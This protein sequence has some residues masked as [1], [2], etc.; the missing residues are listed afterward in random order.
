[1][2]ETIKVPVIVRW[3][4]AAE[5]GRSSGPP[6]GTSPYTPTGRFSEQSL[7]EMFSVVLSNSSALGSSDHILTSGEIVPLFPE[8]I[9]DF[10][11]RLARGDKF[12]LHEGRRAVAECV[13][14][15]AGR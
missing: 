8:K 1:M 7:D 3:Y 12:I 5:G 10:A 15:G 2:T 11:E 4:T 13:V 14:Q 6:L 9:P